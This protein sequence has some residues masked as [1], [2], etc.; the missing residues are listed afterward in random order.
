MVCHVDIGVYRAIKSLRCG[1]Q[2]SV[3]TVIVL[4]CEK[5]G[6]R[7]ITTLDNMQWKTR[8]NNHGMRGTTQLRLRNEMR[9][10]GGAE[11]VRL[12]QAEVGRH[13]PNDGVQVLLPLELVPC[14][15][16]LILPENFTCYLSIIRRSLRK[17]WIWNCLQHVP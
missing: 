10:M 6:L 7:I 3:E 17:Q 15:G 2:I 16:K 9:L 12:C 4:V 13:F 5:E 14:A 1:A 8:N 11:M